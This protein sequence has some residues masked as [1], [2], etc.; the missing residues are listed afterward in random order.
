[1]ESAKE[2]LI[3]RYNVPAPRYTSYP[4]VPYWDKQV[5]DEGRW[6]Q[7]V[8]QT[9]EESNAQKG[10][11]LYLHLPFC[12][13]LCTYCACHTR[14]T[15]NHAVELPYAEAILREWDL[16][17]SQWPQ[18]PHLRELHLGGGTPTFYSP[19][20]LQWLL[21]RLLKGVRLHPNFEF[22]FEGHP[23][24]T[25][26]AHL[27]TLYELGFKRVS[28]GIQDF[29]ERVQRAIHRPQPYQN[30]RN[31]TEQAREMSY[32]SVNFD[33]VYGLPFQTRES[34]RAT[35]E[36]V[37]ELR[38]D[39]IAFYS[40]AHVPWM[41]PGQRSF[42]EADLP[43][44]ESKRALYEMGLEAFT[45]AG[46]ADVGMDH[47]ALPGDGL[48]EAARKG[49]LHRNFMGYTTCQ[50]DLL[51]GLGASAIS[52]AKGAYL[53]NLKSVEAYT[54]SLIEGKLPVLKGHFLTK[55]D[56]II[57]QAIL[58]IVCRGRLNWNSPLMHTLDNQAMQNWRQMEGEGL[59]ELDECGL[60]V[61]PLGQAFVRNVAMVL[62]KKLRE[63]AKGP[64]VPQFS[65]A[66]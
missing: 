5:P 44:S 65:K 9:F 24:N 36:K 47:F 27:Q 64:A 20:N 13:S 10:L 2:Q 40:Y 7:V 51:I 6:S 57:R 8:Q 49:T 50:T 17:R 56:Q 61:T 16:Y 3:R 38:P 46:Y 23:N 1:M 21:E 28:Y 32:T 4:T 12:E 22:S 52:D 58:D 14:I 34:M 53:Q 66:I 48:F 39:R 11:S 41:R 15:R 29:D 31:A 33:L 60:R 43:D 37:I 54:Q 59:L 19:Q 62:D 30:V 35:L 45:R 26:A 63:P 42:T 18:T 55:E 25:T